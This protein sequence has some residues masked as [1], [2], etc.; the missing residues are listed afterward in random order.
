MTDE[1]EARLRAS[2][3]EKAGEAN[4]SDAAWTRISERVDGGERAPRRWLVPAL[5]LGTAAA[6]VT[7]TVAVMGQGEDASDVKVAGPKRA[8]ETT[9][10]TLDEAR[11][12]SVTF[13]GIWPENTWEQY[14]AEMAS[15]IEGGEP[16]RLD[17]VE[18]ATAY[19]H[20]KGFEVPKT[21]VYEVFPEDPTCG[22]VRYTHVG[23]DEAEGNFVEVC[24]ALGS[25][26]GWYGYAGLD[27]ESST[28]T[29]VLD[30]DDLPFVVTGAWTDRFTYM[31]PL[32][33]SQMEFPI[34][35]AVPGT[36]DVRAGAFNSQWMAETSIVVSAEEIVGPGYEVPA[37]LDLGGGPGLPDSIL[38]Q[39]VHRPLVG[40]VMAIT[41]FRLDLADDSPEARFPESL[42]LPEFPESRPPPH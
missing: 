7:V 5:S 38:V 4:P 28:S 15:V 39:I 17:P 33:E 32:Y 26:G 34:G 29:R 42:E 35:I 12:V 11:P 36:L 16:W 27:S 37:R 25:E 22:H 13:P 31:E 18:V 41:E 9:A 3:A 8:T 23:G 6:L 14:R 2:L 40:G 30:L 1:M 21:A 19:L 20:E 10:L 24:R